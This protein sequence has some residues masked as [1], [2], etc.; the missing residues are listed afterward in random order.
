[1][2]PFNHEKFMLFNGI[3]NGHKLITLNL[4]TYRIGGIKNEEHF[5]EEKKKKDK[6][7]WISTDYTLSRIRKK[8]KR[9]K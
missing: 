4:K 3:N 7:G 8:T 6:N 5:K 9:K 1:M 2:G